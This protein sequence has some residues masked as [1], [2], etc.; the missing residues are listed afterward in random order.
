MVP[1]QI[2]GKP[3]WLGSVNIRPHLPFDF[4]STKMCQ[5]PKQEIPPLPCGHPDLGGIEA[6]AAK[7]TLAG[8][9]PQDDRTLVAMVVGVLVDGDPNQEGHDR[10]GDHFH[11]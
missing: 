11:K 4:L 10:D 7:V 2:V 9:G 5:D 1:R 8:V 6:A 3:Q